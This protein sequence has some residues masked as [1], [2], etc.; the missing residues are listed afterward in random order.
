MEY[1]MDDVKPT[2]Q[3]M[4]NIAYNVLYKCNKFKN[5]SYHVVGYSI[6]DICYYS[7]VSGVVPQNFV[8]SPSNV[9]LLSDTIKK[10]RIFL[11]STRQ[12]SEPKYIL[13]IN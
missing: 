7:Y 10:N 12:S 4:F 6:D 2:K 3:E 5:T 9:V 13:N 1:S 11:K 8:W